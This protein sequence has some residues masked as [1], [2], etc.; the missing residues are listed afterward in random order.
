MWIDTHCHLD[1][2]EFDADREAVVA[3]ARAS[4]VTMLVMPTGHIDEEPKVRAIAERHGFAYALGLHPLWLEGAG[5]E[6]LARL[7][8]AVLVARA[9]P[10]FVAVGEIGIDTVDTRTEVARQETFFRE[11]LRIARDAGV[12][13]IVHVRRSA[14]L[15]LKHLRRIEVPGGIIHAFNGSAQQA[16]QFI[17]LKFKLG[18]GGAATYSGSL[19]IRSHAAVLPDEAI[20]LETDAPYIPPVWR[21]IDGQEGRTEPADIARIAAEV[22]SLR[23]V[24]V[25]RLAGINRANAIAALPRL[26]PLLPAEV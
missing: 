4:G 23:G 22:A 11:Q 3:R 18:F 21:R 2:D 24:D 15:L 7:R 13:V 10:R 19:R 6:D 26:A 20:V 14:D 12:P 1:A 17:A 5:D 16:A 8:A 25:N 9:D